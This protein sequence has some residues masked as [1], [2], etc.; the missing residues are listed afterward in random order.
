MQEIIAFFSQKG[1]KTLKKYI[2]FFAVGTKKTADYAIRRLGP[3]CRGPSA[4]RVII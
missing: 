4:F 2:P 3:G 1:A